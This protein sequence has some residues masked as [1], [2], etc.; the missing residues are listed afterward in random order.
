M[1]GFVVVWLCY[2]KCCLFC[3]ISVQTQKDN[4]EK[5]NGL[6]KMK[7]F[8]GRQLVFHLADYVGQYWCCWFSFISCALALWY[9]F[10]A[11]A[12]SMHAAMAPTNNKTLVCIRTHCQICTSVPCNKYTDTHTLTSPVSN[13]KLPDSWI[14]SKKKNC[15]PKKKQNKTAH[16]NRT[17]H[18]SLLLSS[19]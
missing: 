2:A 19:F 13:K 11:Y 14:C 1:F 8:C 7:L 15:E 18:K 6:A 9:P 17:I 16:I 5:W 12:C 4:S 10:T 3:R